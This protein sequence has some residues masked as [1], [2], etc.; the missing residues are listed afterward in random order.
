M[1]VLSVFILLAN[2]ALADTITLRD[3]RTV[4]GSY[5]GGDARNV[6]IAV[7]DRVDSFRVEQI[8]T[9]S[10]GEDTSASGPAFRRSEPR[11]ERAARPPER[12]ASGPEL[13]TG[14]NITVRM[15]DSVDSERDHVGQTFHASLDKPVVDANGNPLIARG[16]PVMV[17][18]VDD[19]QSGKIEGRTILTL[20]VVSIEV[21]GRVVTAAVGAIIG[22]IAGGGKGAAIGAGAGAGAGTAAQVAT[23]GQRVR[24]PSETQLTF[25]L[26][27]PVRL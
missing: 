14:T 20:D 7:G 6:R 8:S 27:Q 17:K 19:K 3:G 15:I 1:R 12:A 26:Q 22:A 9:I 11:E 24:I 2:L 25:V 18:L 5:L 10:F 21:N 4:S 23:K 16:A 13:P